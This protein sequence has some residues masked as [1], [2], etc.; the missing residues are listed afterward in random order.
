MLPFVFFPTFATFTKIAQRQRT[1]M[2]KKWR[3]LIFNNDAIVVHTFT[4]TIYASTQRSPSLVS[5]H[6]KAY[7]ASKETKPLKITQWYKSEQKKIYS[8]CHVLILCS[9]ST[10]SMEITIVLLDYFCYNLHQNAF[11]L[12]FVTSKNI[13]LTP[14]LK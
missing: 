8:G 10:M 4:F 11:M 13:F 1:T 2:A 5:T 6:I 9:W 3:K 14:S 12:I 7:M